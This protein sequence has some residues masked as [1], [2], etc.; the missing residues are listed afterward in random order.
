MQTLTRTTNTVTAI[1]GL[2]G[3]IPAESVAIAYVRDGVYL[4]AA[5]VTA[6]QMNRPGVDH[7]VRLALTQDAQ[8]VYVVA[9]AGDR[10]GAVIQFAE[11]VAEKMAA[12]GVEVAAIAHTF[13]ITEGARWTD[14]RTGNTGEIGDLYS[15]PAALERLSSYGFPIAPSREAIETWFAPVEPVAELPTAE[16]LTIGDR[17]PGAK[18]L[19]ELAETITGY[20]R[21]SDELAARTIAFLSAGSDT[22]DVLL[23]L[24]KAGTGAG[25]VLVEIANRA[26]GIARV[27]LLT[28][29]AVLLY[30]G[31][32][33]PAAN[34]A[35]DQ[36]HDETAASGE[37]TPVLLSLMTTAV[38]VALPPNRLQRLINTGAE[39]ASTDYGIEFDA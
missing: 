24:G 13:A 11:K 7:L 9:V 15:H 1:P 20:A 36:A 25:R 12:A 39:A 8:S 4:L 21:P 34:I 5:N 6:E 10:A 2:L 22:R 27:Q 29:A 32:N 19:R 17:E 14:R 28:V 18:V 26:R 31:G 38:A 33:P 3:Y 30:T 35:I 16:Q 37:E 23:G